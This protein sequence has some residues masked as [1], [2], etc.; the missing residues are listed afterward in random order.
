[1]L[2]A[3]L[4]GDW[5]GPDAGRGGYFSLGKFGLP[6]NIIAV[7][8]GAA[9][10]LN[11]AWPRQEIYNATEPY[12]W[13]LQW[14]AFLFIGVITAIGLAWYWLRGRHRVGTLPEHRV[15]ELSVDPTVPQKDNLTRVEGSQ[16]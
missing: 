1:M 3:R 5:P 12:H 13:Y 14:G 6:I 2:F 15:Q 11:L 9:M 16:A 8:W 4:R 10:A 7:V